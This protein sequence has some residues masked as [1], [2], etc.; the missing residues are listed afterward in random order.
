V[1]PAENVLD[2]DSSE[3]LA[4]NSMRSAPKLTEIPRYPVVAGMALL[5]VG[6]TVAWW[7]KVDIS[8]LFEN[9]MI[10]RGELWRLV[11]SIFPHGGILH[12]VFNVYWLWVF[13]TLVEE[14]YGHFKTA[15]LI[16]LFAIGSGAWEFALAQGGIGL[17]GVG[18]GLFGLLWLLSRRDERF[19]EAI[20][21]KTVQLFV[22]WFFL[23]IATTVTN[24]MPIANIAH[25]TGAVL[26]ILTALAITQPDRRLPITAGIVAILV[27]GLWGA[28]VGRSR[29][30]V[31]G[32]AG[33]EE[34]KWGYDALVA[35][36]NQEAV[37]WLRDAITFQ[38]KMAAYW[39]DLGIAYQGLDD[40]AAAIGAYRKAA[41]LGEVNAEY[42][43]GRLYEAGAPGVPKDVT[44]ALSWYRKS[45]SHDDPE[46]LNNAAWAYATSSDP[47]IH[48]P[49]SALECA[50]KAVSLKKDHPI[51]N[52]LDTL[53]EA[54]Y[55][56]EQYAE[57]VKTER[58][59]IALAPPEARG[60]FEMQLE[61]YQ[62]AL[63]NK[64]R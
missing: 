33:Y 25:G 62:L 47:A 7:A 39:Y 36:R 63:K 4:C 35:H 40:N 58:E 49:S 20:D 15:A 38:P 59:A 42:T 44:Q 1:Y 18:Y 6:V 19:R 14:V 56:N 41:D 22:V 17:S 29:V 9:A 57:A 24:I 10:R 31:S 45:A 61:K 30:N 43:L 34:G 3:L 37:R 52:H 53:A 50:R 12:L 60:N 64:N 48:N 2:A 55:V 54:L 11:T 5:A 13:G 21:P 32:K 51:P 28:T 46:A 8:P 26:G 23:C 16:L 27:F